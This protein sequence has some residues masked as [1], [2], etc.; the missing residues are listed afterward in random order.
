MIEIAPMI[1]IDHVSKRFDGKRRVTALDDVNLAV[2]RGEM[3]SVIG[4]SGS[5]KSTLLNVI[6]GLDR[7]S[8]GQTPRRMGSIGARP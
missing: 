5:G 7:P 3:V 1:E 2:S 8:A 4:P 6:G